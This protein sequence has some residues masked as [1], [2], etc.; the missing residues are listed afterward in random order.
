MA[1]CT[2]KN[3][4]IIVLAGLDLEVGLDVP[5]R[6]SDHESVNADREPKAKL[7]RLVAHG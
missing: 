5:V 2:K 3:E 4:P 1:A 6:L 7:G